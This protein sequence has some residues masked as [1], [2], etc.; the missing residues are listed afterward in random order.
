QYTA[1]RI[2]TDDNYAHAFG[3]AGS[4]GLAL[5][6]ATMQH[7]GYVIDSIFFGL[8]LL[9]LGYLVRRSGYCPKALGV[10]LIVGACCYVAETFAVL[11]DLGTLGD[12]LIIPAGLSEATFLLWLLIRG[13][14]IPAT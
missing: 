14:S 13:G 11:V 8:W 2:A 9:P 4:D 3:R 6:F 12:V 7:G 5:L 1:L 10:L